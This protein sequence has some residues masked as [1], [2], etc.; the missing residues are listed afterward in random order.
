M[1]VK[2]PIP[3]DN[4]LMKVKRKDRL[5]LSPHTA[6]ASVQARERLVRQIA[7]NIAKGW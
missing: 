3:S 2:E 7:E 1:F 4:P 5:R 6:W